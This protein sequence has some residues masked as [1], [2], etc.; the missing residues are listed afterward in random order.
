MSLAG[1]GIDVVP[2]LE[3]V[4]QT[5]ELAGSEATGEVGKIGGALDGR[6]QCFLPGAELSFLD[7]LV[8]L[9]VAKLGFACT[10]PCRVRTGWNQS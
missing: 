2:D 10:Q 4:A 6:W 3:E 1:G 8:G 7:V 9:G 5:I